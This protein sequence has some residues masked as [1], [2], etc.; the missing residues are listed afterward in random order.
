MSA[1][2]GPRILPKG[3][4]ILRS[5]DLEGVFIDAAEVCDTDFDR[6]VDVQFCC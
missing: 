1:A 4:S 3:L 6:A 5:T 2:V